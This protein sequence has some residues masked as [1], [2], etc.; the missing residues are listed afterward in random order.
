MRA[1]NAQLRT[2][3]GAGTIRVARS[4]TDQ[5]R[6]RAYQLF[7]ARNGGPGDATSDWLRAEREITDGDPAIGDAP[8]AE[9]AATTEAER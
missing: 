4:R 7:L 2:A 5:I 9:R 6:Q 3:G 1:Q 8:T